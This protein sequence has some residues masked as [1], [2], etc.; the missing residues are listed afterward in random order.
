[1]SLE[2]RCIGAAQTVTGSRH[3]IRTAHTTLLIDCGLY[4][5]H[6]RESNERNRNLGVSPREV[7]AVVLSHAHIDHSG[8]LP[9]LC[10]QGY[11]GPIYTTHAT[12]DLCAVMLQDAA[13]IQASDARYLKARPRTAIVFI[14]P[15]KSWTISWPKC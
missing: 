1:M 6:R 4:Q 10:K 11:S 7:D 15:S 2:I 8:A 9:M 3:L 5:G 13:N 12:R 14:H